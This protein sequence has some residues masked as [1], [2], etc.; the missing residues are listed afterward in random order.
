[1]G[2]STHPTPGKP[3]R[4]SR[5]GQPIMVIFDLLG[6]SW[7]M[8]IIWHL[9]NGPSTFRKLQEYCEN[10]SP[11]TLNKRLKELAKADIIERTMGGYDLTT[12]GKE[13]FRLLEPLGLWAKNWAQNYKH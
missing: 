2:Y 5:T 3:V 10:I 6:R 1:M 8:G 12:D 9:N 13:L 7:S 11:T 4:G